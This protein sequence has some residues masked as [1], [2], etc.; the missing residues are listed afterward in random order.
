MVEVTGRRGRRCKQLL[1]DLK[2]TR[3]WAYWKLK[4]EA[5]RRTCCG[6]E[7][8]PV[9]RRTTDWIS[10]LL[11][12]VASA[13]LQDKS[14]ALPPTPNL[15]SPP[16]SRYTAWTIA[17]PGFVKFCSKISRAV[18]TIALSYGTYITTFYETALIVYVPCLYPRRAVRHHYHSNRGVPLDRFLVSY[19]TLQQTVMVRYETRLSR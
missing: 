18:S 17:V 9:V 8:G 13:Q 5:Q 3:G 12:H 6:I 11:L 19:Y 1:D 7:Y 14:L 4:E 15:S 10:V 2:E 16:T